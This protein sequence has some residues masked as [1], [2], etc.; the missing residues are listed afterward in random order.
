M[1]LT[2]CLRA[3]ETCNGVVREVSDQE[4]LDAKA[5][6]GAGGLGCEPASAASVAGAKRLVRRTGD[7]PRRARRL[8]PHGPSTQRPRQPRSPIT[9]PIRTVQQ[10]P[11]QPRRETRRFAN[12]P[13]AVKNDLDE[14][15]RAIQLNSYNNA[16]PLAQT[17]VRSD[18]QRTKMNGWLDDR[19]LRSF[20]IPF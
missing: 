11:R 15:I 14:I 20:G 6:V 3:L 9:R 19:V 12:R 5:Q 2:K 13:V 7:R 8:H 4:I 18:V 17:R 1:N 10:S 16:M